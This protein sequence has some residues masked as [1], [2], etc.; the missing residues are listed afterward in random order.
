MRDSRLVLSA[1]LDLPILRIELLYT[2][3]LTIQSSLRARL[4][5]SL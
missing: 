5:S 4:L 2:V 1:F 3:R